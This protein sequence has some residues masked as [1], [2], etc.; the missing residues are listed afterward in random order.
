[1]K[2][3]NKILVPVDL[4][5]QSSSAIDYALLIS[6]MFNAK[7][8]CI[9]VIDKN[10]I[11]SLNTAHYTAGDF[12]GEIEKQA[13]IKMNDLLT[14][15]LTS[16]TKIFHEIIWGLPYKDISDYAQK[17]KIDLIVMNSHTKSR[18]SRFFLGSV[19]EKVLRYSKVPV[20]ILKQE[21]KEDL[22]KKSD[23]E[24]ELH[25]Y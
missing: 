9:H 20:L 15:Y 2:M 6:T 4:T 17:N 19:A 16:D 11:I 7:I 8:Y 22:I 13:N 25:L 3:I 18:I 1:M 5:E 14:K 10:S 23:I 24:K 12:L 21:A